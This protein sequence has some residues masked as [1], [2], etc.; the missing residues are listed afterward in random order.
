MF[1]LIPVTQ[2]RR[3]SRQRAGFLRNNLAIAGVRLSG[4]AV[5]DELFHGNHHFKHEFAGRAGE[6]SDEANRA[7]SC[8]R[9]FRRANRRPSDPSGAGADSDSSARCWSP[10]TAAIPCGA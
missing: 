9:A 5:S 10:T 3:V 1:P 8:V 2:L 6:M 4:A 7:R